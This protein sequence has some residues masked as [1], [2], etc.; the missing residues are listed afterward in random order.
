M[1]AAIDTYEDVKKYV[2]KRRQA[3]KAGT[4]D[5][6]P[7]NPTN[8]DFRF[9]CMDAYYK[10]E[11]AHYSG[12]A[13]GDKLMKHIELKEVN[14]ID[15][16]KEW[17]RM[18][19]R[20]DL[21]NSRKALKEEWDKK[22][23]K[24][25][26]DPLTNPFANTA[27]KATHQKKLAL[28]DIQKKKLAKAAPPGQWERLSEEERDKAV[29][30]LLGGSHVQFIGGEEVAPDAAEGDDEAPEAPKPKPAA[31]KQ[32]VM[33]KVISLLDPEPSELAAEDYPG[34]CPASHLGVITFGVS[35][36][37]RRWKRSR[38]LPRTR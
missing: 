20:R 22:Q 13:T 31:K 21:Y 3:E 26:L 4:P 33:P 16:Y 1:A 32:K 17:M 38:L 27:A 23:P 6:I 34:I 11:I 36:M 19:G 25:G 12:W 10:E 30:G 15:E 35:Q 28:A 7:W 5:V 29:Q 37:P 8:K 9:R 18:P 24:L 14:E 2:A